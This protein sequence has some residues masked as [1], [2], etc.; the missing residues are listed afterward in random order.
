MNK[1]RKLMVAGIAALLV[2]SLTVLAAGSTLNLTGNSSSEVAPPVTVTMSTCNRPPGFIL[3]IANLSGFNDSIGHGA[4]AHPWPVVH[5][6]KGQEVNFL[7]CNLDQTQAHG[8][9]ITYYFD[10]GVPIMPGEAYRIVFTATKAGTFTI[11]C[12]I[13]CTIHIYMRG[14]LIVS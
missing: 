2:I 6:E 14:Q 5:V 13:F 11:Y 12:N 1:S 10:S 7:V 9:A 8:F 4:P 3:I